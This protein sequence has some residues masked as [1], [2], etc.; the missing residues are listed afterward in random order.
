MIL[1]NIFSVVELVDSEA[2][3]RMFEEEMAFDNRNYN[4]LNRRCREVDSI[5]WESYWLHREWEE[6]QDR[7]RGFCY[8]EPPPP[9]EVFDDDVP[10]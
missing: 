7:E 5:Y 8:W 9:K 6:R 10:F 2:L 3:D 4:R 1:S